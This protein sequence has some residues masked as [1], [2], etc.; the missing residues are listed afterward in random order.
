MS[1]KDDVYRYHLCDH[2]ERVGGCVGDGPVTIHSEVLRVRA[3]C[4]SALRRGRTTLV[5]RTRSFGW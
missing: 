2:E 5:G 1:Q 4:F 3:T